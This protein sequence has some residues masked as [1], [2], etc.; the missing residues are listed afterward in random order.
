MSPLVSARHIPALDGLR[1]LCV[2]CVFIEH[3]GLSGQ[4]LGNFGVHGFF[5]LSGYLIVGILHALRLRIEAGALT[6]GAAF[7]DFWYRRILRI[8]PAYYLVLLGL[9]LW[10]WSRGVPDVWAFQ[11]L[12]YYYGFLGNYY[13]G[14]LGGG[15]GH[16]SHLW[17][18]SVEQHFYMLVSP[19]LLLLPARWHGGVLGLV[20]LASLLWLASAD[21]GGQALRVAISSLTCFLYL[22]SGGLLALWLK[23]GR[24]GLSYGL[25]VVLPLVGVLGYCLSQ[26]LFYIF[27]SAGERFL[28]ASVS[29]AIFATWLVLD[30]STDER[31]VLVRFFSRPLLRRLGEVSYGF[32]LYHYLFPDFLP[33]LE[34]VGL[35]FA[36]LPWVARGIQFGLTWV[37]A[38]CSWRFLEQPLLHLKPARPGSQVQPSS[39]PGWRGG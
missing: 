26:D 27:F 22:A 20:C 31:G 14:P 1:G 2:L 3:F 17:S 11:G 4:G 35:S 24:R 6:V 7:R 21:E 36:G 19:A 18:L 23:N 12:A 29:M 25:G 38:W 5:V 13:V 15:W 34:S 39:A 28:I 32:Y 8:F 30:L 9:T 37:L 10:Y 33:L 16:F